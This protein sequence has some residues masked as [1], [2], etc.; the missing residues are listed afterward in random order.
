MGTLR[1]E[2]HSEEDSEEDSEK[3]GHSQEAVD[4]GLARDNEA[5]G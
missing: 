2:E 5:S 1:G 4:F 3:G